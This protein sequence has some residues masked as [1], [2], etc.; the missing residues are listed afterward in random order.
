MTY[1]KL[2]FNLLIYPIL[3]ILSL[4]VDLLAYP[5]ALIIATVSLYTPKLPKVFNIWLTHDNPIDGDEG[6][7]QR[8]PDSS[9]KFAIW[10]RRI[11]WLWRNKGYTFDYKYLGRNIGNTLTNYGN[12]ETTDYGIEGK[13][14]QFDENGVWEFYLIKRYFFNKN[15]CLRIRL[16]WKLDDTKVSTNERMMLATSI[17]L[18]KSFVEKNKI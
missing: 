12:P 13:I 11:A 9:T 16:G 17:G 15:K 8:H 7:L 6:H 4:I 10:K 3:Y 1:L 14:F 18:W 5:M 2:I